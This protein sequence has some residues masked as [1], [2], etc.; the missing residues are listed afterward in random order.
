M[1][2]SQLMPHSEVFNGRIKESENNSSCYLHVIYFASVVDRFFFKF[3]CNT[4]EIIKF[5][6]STSSEAEVFLQ[7]S[8]YTKYS[9]I[10]L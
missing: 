10:V 8:A 3:L 2:P 6:P 9:N 7:K 4:L 1:F 5:T